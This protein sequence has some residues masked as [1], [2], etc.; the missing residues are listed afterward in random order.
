MGQSRRRL[1]IGVAAT[2]SRI[3]PTLV[4]DLMALAARLYP[5][6]AP[7]F[8]VHPNAFLQEGHFAGSDARRAEA[9]LAL[10]NDPSIDAVWIARG[11]YGACRLLPE[12]MPHLSPCARDK[13]Y[14]GYSDA[15]ALLA[16][17]YGA[18][19]AFVAHGP[20]P[21]DLRRDGGESAVGRAMAWL[22]EADARGLEPT[23][24]QGAPTAAF[25]LTILSTLVGGPWL[26]DLD[27]HVLMV[28]EVSEHLYRIDRSF[29]HVTSAPPIRRAAGLMLGR[30]SLIPPNDPDFGR[31]EEQIARDWCDRS[32]LAWLGRADIGHD[33][34]NKIVPFGRV[35]RAAG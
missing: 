8:V 29:F 18:G 4:D 7:R 5:R 1:N 30:C 9:F 24:A 2:G 19:F 33:V 17:L 27:G 26:P 21:Q 14:L 35:A 34:D 22:V 28:E 15:G 23:A 32:G 11:G 25:N 16:A 10:A 3:D 20:M 12:I 6:D 31:T 13:A